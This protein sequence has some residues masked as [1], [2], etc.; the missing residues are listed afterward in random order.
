M[1]RTA[2]RLSRQAA[3]SSVPAQAFE[4]E[5]LILVNENDR[6]LGSCGKAESHEAVDTKAPLHRAFSVFLFDSKNRLLMQQRS[7]KKPTYPGLFTNTCCSH[8]RFNEQEMNE[9]GNIGIKTAAVRRLK[10]ELG[11]ESKDIVP[12]AMKFLGKI[13]YHSKNYPEHA[14]RRYSEHEI[15]YMLLVKADVEVFPNV[16]EV[17]WARYMD[18]DEVKELLQREPT[19]ITPWFRFIFHSLLLEKWKTGLDFLEEV[20]GK[21]EIVRAG[22][23]Q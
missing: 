8:P 11:I 5:T 9:I 23:L 1:F 16:D 13:H 22:E 7:E 19:V 17:A 2:M 12:E 21:T 3:R 18:A 20:D 14:D 10:F 6:V 4:S 15:D